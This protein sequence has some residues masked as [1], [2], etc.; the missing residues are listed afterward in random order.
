M[1][2]PDCTMQHG[3]IISINCQVWQSRVSACVVAQ[4]MGTA[5]QSSAALACGILLH[6]RCLFIVVK[7]V[8]AGM[9]PARACLPRPC[10][11]PGLHHGKLYP[12]TCVCGPTRTPCALFERWHCVFTHF[13]HNQAVPFGSTTLR[14]CTAQVFCP[15][16]YNSHTLHRTSVP[17]WHR[18]AIACHSASRVKCLLRTY[19]L[20]S[21]WG[22]RGP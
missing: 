15:Q 8:C 21:P 13:V 18:D 14:L 11:A 10:R 20:P 19:A 2:W 22:K 16:L 5:Q 12:D 7:G 3:D 17:V 1:N 4:G 6:A 9:H